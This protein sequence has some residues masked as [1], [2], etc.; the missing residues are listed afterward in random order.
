MVSIAANIGG[1]KILQRVVEHAP[2]LLNSGYTI[3]NILTIACHREGAWQI[4]IEESLM[5]GCKILL[6]EDAP[7]VS[8]SSPQDSGRDN[9]GDKN[10]DFDFL[11]DVL[12]DEDIGSLGSPNKSINA[13]FKSTTRKRP[14]ELMTDESGN[15]PVQHHK[16]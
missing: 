5:R 12:P 10:Y 8:V 1:S 2:N 11:E 4:Q 15:T 16:F 14:Y 9:I 13:F 6:E 7:L 3:D